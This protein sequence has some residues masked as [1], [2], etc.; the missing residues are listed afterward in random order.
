[1]KEACRIQI[2]VLRNAPWFLRPA[3][4]FT[5]KPIKRNRL[6]QVALFIQAGLLLLLMF[7]SI[8]FA[9][10]SSNQETGEPYFDSR[11]SK[12]AFDRGATV[13]KVDSAVLAPTGERLYTLKDGVLYQYGLAPLMKINSID[14]DFDTHQ[15]KSLPYRVFVS[16]NEKRII[17]YQKS[18]LR[19]LDMET[20]RII[21]DVPFESELG[22]LND[23]EFLTLD[24]KN[25]GT[26]WSVRELIKKFEFVETGEARW[27]NTENDDAR[28]DYDISYGNVIKAN[29]YIV[30]CRSVGYVPG[31]V[32][33]F[34]SKSYNQIW[35]IS[36]LQIGV[37]WISYDLATLYI[38]KYG[39]PLWHSKKY[40]YRIYEPRESKRHRY[41]GST[42]RLH[43]P[44]N[45]Y[46]VIGMTNSK[47]RVRLASTG[48]GQQVSPTNQY[49][50]S[51]AIGHRGYI[52][53]QYREEGRQN[54][55]FLQF[56]DG[57]A[58]LF[59]PKTNYFQLTAN[60]R[61]HL[62]MKN[63][64]GEI[65]PINDATYKKYNKSGDHKEW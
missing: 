41:P 50:M 48:R 1:M 46:E 2:G 47:H 34:D 65:V 59:E 18:R 62:K 24:N 23:D 63:R 16:N 33:V 4:T 42:L 31:E 37:P 21:R 40:I 49:Y 55:Y 26:V 58:A 51:I 32:I 30:L 25:T 10:E 54:K 9:Y 53:F 12:G 3:R 35:R 39:E 38:P 29:N 5:M 27:A 13:G 11:N 22:A 64:R 45:K 60:A 19:L 57:E 20:G 36:Y 61:K 17:I 44:T 14:V 6:I 43:L 52:G 8:A 56:E 7:P 28:Y 15:T